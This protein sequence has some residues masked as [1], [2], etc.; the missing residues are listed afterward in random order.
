MLR[1][2]QNVTVRRPAH[3]FRPQA[4]PR[5]R[6]F[7]NQQKSTTFS[8]IG[9][10][11]NEL[12]GLEARARSELS[13]RQRQKLQKKA[14]RM[15][16]DIEDVA[17]T[18][19]RETA[20]DMTDRGDLRG[21]RIGDAVVGG[22]ITTGIDAKLAKKRASLE[23]TGDS[24]AAADAY[25]KFD[26]AE[27]QF[28]DELPIEMTQKAKEAARSTK[29]A[30]SAKGDTRNTPSQTERIPGNFEGDMA[31]LE[32]THD[33]AEELAG[34]RGPYL[35]EGRLEDMQ[36]ERKRGKQSGGK[37]ATQTQASHTTNAQASVRG[38]K[39][40]DSCVCVMVARFLPS[41]TSSIL[42]F[43]LQSHLVYL[44]V[45]LTPSSPSLR[46]VPPS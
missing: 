25:A 8:E 39:H 32:G 16:N 9:R 20:S 21:M 45:C 44:Y 12:N 7:A 31:P 18:R 30:A 3:T 23:A 1:Y 24:A 34:N 15:A 36:P 33:E 11:A 19:D 4:P 13:E 29:A 22:P 26:D 46:A 2:R 42:A 10:N 28:Y 27:R 40:F 38:T 6:H 41:C 17:M 43:Y 35:R 37:A 14:E 5:P